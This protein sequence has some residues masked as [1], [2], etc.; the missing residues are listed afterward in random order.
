MAAGSFQAFILESTG[1]TGWFQPNSVCGACR[2]DDK[3]VN[4][5]FA[6]RAV[7]VLSFATSTERCIVLPLVS[8]M[9]SFL[10]GQ[11]SWFGR[12][13]WDRAETHFKIGLMLHVGPSRELLAAQRNAPLE[14]AALNGNWRRGTG[15]ELC[16][17]EQESSSM[18]FSSSCAT[19]RFEN[20][21]RMEMPIFL[22]PRCREVID[23]R[24]SRTPKNTNRPFYTY[25]MNGV[26]NWSSFS[27]FLWSWSLRNTGVDLFGVLAG[28]M[29]F[30]FRLM[31]WP[32]WMMSS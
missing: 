16:S 7:Y 11:R 31:F 14:L 17:G 10:P 30:S 28:E 18:S 3:R 21:A 1:W 29:L 25:N 9:L 8:S 4:Y 13:R 24:L 27:L 22:C 5:S 2:A 20:S 23:R 12:F 26:R 32:W 19:S 6:I 15:L